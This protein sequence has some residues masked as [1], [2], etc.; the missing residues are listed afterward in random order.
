MKKILIA[1]LLLVPLTAIAGEDVYLDHAP[2]NL[3]DNA[4]IQRGAQLFTNYCLGCHSANYMRYITLEQVGL[5]EKQ[6]KN[7]LMFTADNVGSHMTIAMQHGDAKKWFGTAPPD[8]SVIARVRTPDWLYTYLRS[9]YLDDASPTGWNNT[10][11][12]KVAMPHVLWLLQ[13]RQVLKKA[14]ENGSKPAFELVV[15]G[16]MT[17]DQY[18]SAVGD[19]VN[20]LTFMSEPAKLKRMEVG[21][22]VLAF[23]GLFFVLTYFLKKEFW[24]DIH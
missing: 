18:D 17:P 3:E 13:G 9:F 20:Y 8:L 10:V 11:Y 21:L 4:S 24:K 22:Y 16:K 15:P 2:V 7:N 1:L 6:I 19:L 5:T 23:L 12:D 14:G